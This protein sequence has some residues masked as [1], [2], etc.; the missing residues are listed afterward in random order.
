M[1]PIYDKPHGK[2]FQGDCLEAMRTFKE[3]TFTAVVSDFPFGIKITGNQWDND[4]PS[5][6]H[7]REML[8]ITKPGGPLL[9]FGHEKTDYKLKYN[10]VEAGWELETVI[11]WIYSHGFPKGLDISK[12]IDAHYGLER[13]VIGTREHPTL[14]DENKVNRNPRNP[15]ACHGTNAMKNEWEITAPA[16]EM[17]EK[18]DGY[19]TGL[20]LA[21]TPIIVARKPRKGTVAENAL[22]HGVAGWNIGDCMVPG[23]DVGG[24]PINR[25]T[26]NVFFEPGA[27]AVLDKISGPLQSNGGITRKKGDPGNVLGEYGSIVSNEAKTIGGASEFFQKVFYSGRTR[28]SEKNAGVSGKGKNHHPSVKPIGLMRE[29]LR[30]VKMPETNLILDP[31][32]GTFT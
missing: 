10:L 27:A 23:T 9:G 31:Y 29:L 8:R 12:S 19:R 14:K 16:C 22:I 13:E 11:Y 1:K 17:S 4:V 24:E 3:N 21:V 32:A 6:A 26:A 5:V 25:Y 18:W 28:A 15:N 20:K 7:C 2:V 30:L